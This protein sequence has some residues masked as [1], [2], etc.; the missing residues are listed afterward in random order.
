MYQIKCTCDPWRPKETPPN[1]SAL[2]GLNTTFMERLKKRRSTNVYILLGRLWSVIKNV[3]FADIRT[4]LYYQVCSHTQALGYPIG[5]HSFCAERETALILKPRFI[6][7]RRSRVHLWLRVHVLAIGF[8]III[9][10]VS[11][12]WLAR[13]SVDPCHLLFPLGPRSHPW[14]WPLMSRGSVSR[15]FRSRGRVHFR[16]CSSCPCLSRSTSLSPHVFGL[17]NWTKK[18]KHEV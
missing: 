10:V 2:Q 1:H 18:M 7:A 8:R 4:R 9:H 11:S 12:R 5:I 15:S 13:S 14:R 17:D 16:S 6:L 3:V